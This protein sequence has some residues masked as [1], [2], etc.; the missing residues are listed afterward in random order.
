MTQRTPDGQQGAFGHD[1]GGGRSAGAGTNGCCSLRAQTVSTPPG[2][3]PFS[4]RADTQSRFHVCQRA[5]VNEE[6]IGV[7]N[8]GTWFTYVKEIIN[9]IT[10][11]QP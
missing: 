2:L 8:S 3:P 4:S 10:W 5:R 1:N 9:T 7:N 6:R 11:L